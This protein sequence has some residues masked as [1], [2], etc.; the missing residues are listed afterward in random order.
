M[1]KKQL[2]YC[3]YTTAVTKND[4]VANL[5]DFLVKSAYE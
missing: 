5:K 4:T 1:S 2:K 3:A